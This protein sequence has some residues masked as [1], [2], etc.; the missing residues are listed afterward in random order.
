MEQRV[1]AR[2]RKDFQVGSEDWNDLTFTGQRNSLDE[3]PQSGSCIVVSKQKAIDELEEIP[4]ERNTKEDLHCTPA[5]HTRY[6]CKIHWLQ[7]RTLF[8]CCYSFSRCAA[9]A[10][11]PKIGCEGSQQA[12]RNFSSGHLQDH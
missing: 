12:V 6:R 7:S 4:V 5:I 8:Q 9:K 3:D 1:L 2:L 11:S 10:A